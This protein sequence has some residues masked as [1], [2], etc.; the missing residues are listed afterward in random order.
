MDTTTG[1]KLYDHVFDTYISLRVGMAYIAF[2][3]PIVVVG[4]GLLFDRGLPI[5]DSLSAYYW[6]T[7]TGFNPSRIVFVGGLF[8]VGAFLYL[9][10]GFTREENLALNAAA[11]FAVGV[12]CFPMKWTCDGCGGWTPHGL[13]A[14]GLFGCLVYVVWFRA[15]DTLKYLPEGVSQTPYKLKY[16][17][18]GFFMLASPV[19][20][21][22]IQWTVG[23]N[24]FVIAVEALGIWAFASYWLV[25][26]KEL[27]LSRATKKA[28]DKQLSVPP[29]APS[30]KP[31]AGRI[32]TA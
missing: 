26:G 25:K 13:C 1:E 12:A 21:L 30:T 24:K 27:S 19:I 5:Q 11:I 6:A 17:I 7:N 4:V 14:F 9:Y 22:I 18:I 28:L 16:A 31:A 3:F 8:A 2:A 10:K 15:R 29:K 32:R 23:E 20:A